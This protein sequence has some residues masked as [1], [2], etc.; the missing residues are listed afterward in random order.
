MLFCETEHY[1]LLLGMPKSPFADLHEITHRIGFGQ[2]A[3]S[4]LISLQNSALMN[5]I[6]TVSQIFLF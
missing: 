5:E 6:G 4:F 1:F 2:V 3:L